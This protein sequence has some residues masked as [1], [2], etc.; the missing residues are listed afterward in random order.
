VN[1]EDGELPHLETRLVHRVDDIRTF[2]DGIAASYDE[3]HGDAER[4]LRY[5]LTII[6]GLLQGV[7]RSRLV[8]IGCGNGLHLFALAGEFDEVTGVDLSPGMIAAAEAVRARHAHCA[9]VR[10]AVDPAES[11]QS[12]EN[13]S[14]DAVLCVGAFEHMPEK[15]EVLRQVERVLKSGGAFICLSANGSYV[16]YTRLAP[17]LGLAT[18]HL[19]TD[20]FVRDGEWLSLLRAADLTPAAIGHWRFVPAGDM[21]PWA[22]VLM[23]ALDALGRAL[24]MSCLR[25]GCY[26]KAVKA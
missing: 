11:L 2:F 10:L 25:G 23:S 22:R 26:V 24:K 19:S 3:R 7:K 13:D 6:R 5:R 17:W 15:D 4:L 8:E 1:T 9:R 20:R 21:P 16:W 18:R 12:V 14:A